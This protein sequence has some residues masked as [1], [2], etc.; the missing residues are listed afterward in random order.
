MNG[1]IK[2]ILNLLYKHKIDETDFNWD[3]KIF[4]KF[5]LTRLKGLYVTWRKKKNWVEKS[6]L[7]L[8]LFIQ[9]P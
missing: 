3:A 4:V 8:W 9:N 5:L 2:F 7:K 6:G 1:F